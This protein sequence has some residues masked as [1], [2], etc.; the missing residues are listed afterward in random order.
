VITDLDLREGRATDLREAFGLFERAIQ[1]TAHRMGA[2]ERDGGLD[3]REIEEN[4]KLER[5][6]VEFMAAQDGGC[7]W[8]AEDESG[9]VGFARTVLFDRM[10]QLTEVAVARHR[11]GE[12]IGRTLLQRCW[13]ESPTRDVGRLIVAAGSTVDLSLYAEFGAMPAAGHWHLMVRT[14]RFLERRSQEATDA[15]DPGVHLL[16]PDR[17]VTEWK[18]LEPLALAHERP[19]LHDF[20]GRERTCIATLDPDGQATALCWVAPRGYIGPGVGKR[21]EDLVPVVLA[22]LDRVAKAQEPEELHLFCATD[23][24]WLLRRLRALGFR[25]LWPSWV[26]CSEPLPGLDRYLPTRPALVL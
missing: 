15:A 13:P 11:Q 26:M 9:M 1:G 25:V 10:E 6:L 16:S 3:E 4:W 18:R 12:G 7:F 14:E 17:A 2:V 22:A 21:P 8:V 20:F 23:S 24:W 19:L 5:P